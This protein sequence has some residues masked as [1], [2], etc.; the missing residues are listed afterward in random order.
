MSRLVGRDG[1]LLPFATNAFHMHKEAQLHRLHHE[2]TGLNEDL[3]DEIRD[4]ENIFFRYDLI[5]IRFLF[6]VADP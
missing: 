6:I 5:C 2:E 3:I 1:Y 4:N